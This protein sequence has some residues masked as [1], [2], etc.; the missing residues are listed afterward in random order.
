MQL[1]GF[2]I[3]QNVCNRFVL[4]IV[5]VQQAVVLVQAVRRGV[6]HKPQVGERH[7]AFGKQEKRHGVDPC[8][9]A[10]SFGKVCQGVGGR[11]PT[12]V[13]WMLRRAVV[14]VLFVHRQVAQN[15]P[16]SSGRRDAVTHRCT[17]RAP[18][19]NLPLRQQFLQRGARVKTAAETM[20]LVLYRRGARAHRIQV[21]KVALKDTKKW[22]V[23]PL[24]LRQVCETANLTGEPRGVNHH[25]PS[26]FR[27][28][29]LL[30]KRGL[31]G[32]KTLVVQ[33][34]Q[35]VFF[36]PVL[37]NLVNHVPSCMLRR[38]CLEQR[39]PL[40]RAL[41]HLLNERHRPQAVVVHQFMRGRDSAQQRVTLLHD[42]EWVLRTSNG[43]FVSIVSKVYHAVHRV[44][45]ALLAQQQRVVVVR[46]DGLRKVA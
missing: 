10:A 33:R 36:V 41:Q 4:S 9:A 24:H 19:D 15:T 32:H 29:S 34:F 20:H 16:H 31:L 21:S 39:L 6:V 46:P 45:H 30:A 40:F 22:K 44:R 7:P 43:K 12:E 23:H 2:R 18:R 13:R 27:G 28:P 14:R 37:Q 42:G 1:L 26:R 8:I 3:A 35:R 5:Q 25:V 17:L 38:I 11:D